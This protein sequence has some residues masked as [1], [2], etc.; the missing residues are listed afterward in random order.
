MTE[1]TRDKYDEAEF[2]LRQMQKNTAN[3]PEFKYYFSAFVSAGRSITFVL[4]KE[5]KDSKYGE[6]FQSWYGDTSSD[7]LTEGT[8]QSDLSNND[9][10]KFVLNAR[11]TVLKEGAPI[12]TKTMMTAIQEPPSILEIMEKRGM[13]VPEV[14]FRTREGELLGSTVGYAWKVTKQDDQIMVLSKQDGDWYALFGITRP[15]LNISYIR[16]YY[17]FSGSET[18]ANSIIC[19]VCEEYMEIIDSYL[20]EWEQFI[21]GKQ[22]EDELLGDPDQ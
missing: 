3:Q 13:S 1:L 9:I 11:N 22:T 15:G 21:S 7:G 2:F 12:T 17:K 14:E 16:C 8:V 18:T 20:E 19:D 5:F 10:C 6:V 4:D